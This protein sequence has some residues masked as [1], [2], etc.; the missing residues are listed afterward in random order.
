MCTAMMQR[1][2]IGKLRIRRD[3]PKRSACPEPYPVKV[4]Y[5]HNRTGNLRIQVVVVLKDFVIV[6]DLE[7]P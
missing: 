1:P 2:G 5:I 4:M 3:L 6:I 7:V